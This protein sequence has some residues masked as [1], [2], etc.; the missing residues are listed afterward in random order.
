MK[1]KFI[2]L[3]F[4]PF[5]SWALMGSSN[6]DSNL[7]DQS[8]MDARAAI[9]NTA[10]PLLIPTTTPVFVDGTVTPTERVLPPIGGNAGLV[11]GAS[12]LVLIIIGGVVLTSRKKAK[13]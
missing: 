10:T 8:L 11:L 9:D 5:I 4:I 3:L 13:H 6:R 12:V 7:K 2:V 1:I